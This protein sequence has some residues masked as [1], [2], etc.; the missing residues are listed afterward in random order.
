ML[1]IFWVPPEARWAHL[2]AQV[3]QPT[4]GQLVGDA[5]VGIERDNPA[6]KGAR[7][8]D[9]ARPALDKTRLGQ[10]IDMVSNIKVGDEASRAKDVL[11]RVYEYFLSQFASAEGKKGGEFYTPRC[12]VKP[13][14]EML[15]PYRGRVY[16]PCCGSSGLFVQSVEFIRAQAKGN[17]NGGKAKADISIYGQESNYTTWRLAKMNLAIRGIDGQI[18]HGDTFHNDRHLD[19]K[20]DSILANLPF[21]VS[22]AATGFARGQVLALRPAACRQRHLR[23]GHNAV[24]LE[25]LQ[26]GASVRGIL[27][28]A[29]VSVVNVQW[30]GSDALTLVYRGPN[31]RVADEILYRHDEP[32]LEV[33]EA[34][35]PWSFDGDGAL[36]RLVSEAHR[37]R[38]AHLFDPVL[39]VHTSLVD[40]LPHQITAVYEAMLPRQPLRFLLADD[41][42]AGKTIMAGLLIKELI[43]RGDLRR[44]LIV[45]PGSLVEQWQDEL[46]RRFHLPFEILTNDKLEAAR[47]GNW[48]LE[49]DLAIARL[50][51]LSRDEDVQEKLNAPDCRYDLI[52]CDEAHK[53]SATFFGGEVKY[54]KRYRLGQLLSG[55]TRHFL[56][57]T[58]TPHNGKEEDFQLFLAL[59]DGDRFEGRFRDGVHQVEV[60]DLM[61]RMVKEKLL[62]FDGRPLFPERIAY[63]VPYKLSNAEAHLYKQVTEYVREEFNRAEA[64]QNDKRAGTVGFALTILQRRLASSP[65]AIYQSLHRRR[66]RLEKRLRELE[67]LQRGA[68]AAPAVASGPEL[69]DDDINDL[70]EAPENEVEATEE[71]ILDQATAASTIAELKAE[72]AT[73]TRLETLAADVRRSGQDTKWR[74]LAHLLSEIFTPAGLSDRLAEEPPPYGAGPL[75]KPT[76][77]PRQKLVLFTEHRDTLNYL[78]RQIGSLLGR[79]QAVVMIHGGKGREDRR[80]AQESFLHDPEVQVLLATDAAGE[81]INLQRA[82]LMVNYDLPWNPNRLEQRFGRIHRIG[83]TE[84]CHLWNL[85]AAETREGDVYRRLLEKLEEARQALGGQV[86][87]V[88]GKLQFEGRPLRELLIEAI[89]YGDEPEVR[90]R[91]TRAIENGVD[92]P[93]LQDLLEERA[94]AHDAMDASRVARVREEMERADARRLQPHYIESFFLEAFGH[95]SGTARQ[96]EPRRY[97]ISHVPSPVRNRDR[98]IGT[99]DPVLARYERIAFEKDLIAQQGQPLAAFVC[100]GHPLLDAVLDLT[101]ERHRD[102]LKR[103]TV[104]VDERDAGTSPRVLFFLEHAIQDASLL[105][106]GERRTIS[107]RMLYV[108]MDADEEARHLYYAPYLDYRP[109]KPDEPDITAVLTRSE[110]SWITRALEQKAQSHAIANVVPSHIKEVRDRRL[111]WVEKTRAAVKDRLTKEIAY[112]DHRAAQLKLQEEAG[113]A[114]ARLNSGEARKRADDLQTRLEKRLAELDREAQMSA[115]PPVVLGGLVVVPIGLIALMTG[116]TAP[117]Q[118]TVGDTQASAAR[119]RAI[120]MELERAF[121]FEP[122]DREYEKTRLRHREPS[123]RHRPVALHRSERARDGCRN[124]HGDEERNPHVSQQAGR[125]HPRARRVPRR[126]QPSRALSAAAVQA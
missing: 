23:Q 98:Q 41:P 90:A 43:A 119:A 67:L 84:V 50:D 109:L 101:L 14:V 73:L 3:R 70:E 125:L 66:E 19:F 29:L 116:S 106:S 48:F 103:G 33:V 22:V 123:V 27:P 95:L 59:L 6:L 36:F 97:E 96:R 105:P 64:L 31:G 60:S 124:H 28:D 93:H 56:L 108:E 85:V 26:P 91:L 71:Q 40:P 53:F 30:H 65:E 18:A 115:L 113:R 77:S 17:A 79:P 15:E 89:R 45:C 42:G 11:G 44:C 122:T 7:P 39:A 72:I 114:G 74:E 80:K 9:Y 117:G 62:K 118:T 20:A 75:P 4:I 2:K 21:S 120:V 107:R 81:G 104:L 51:K 57:M 13:L 63:T 34:G 121:G 47:T 87:D 69:D 35:R 49:N 37:I 78:E 25:D 58:A 88:L 126:R 32:R 8:K 86:F 1:S 76:P 16:D 10:L 99:G 55:L 24:R 94:L 38:L 110:C 68:A 12:V 83:Q 100:P 111:A 54:T 46:H 82:H 92:R 5:M 52:V 61:R 112:W 102:L